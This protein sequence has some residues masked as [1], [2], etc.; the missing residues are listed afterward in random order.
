MLEIKGKFVVCKGSLAPGRLPMLTAAALA[1]VVL[2][3][4]TGRQ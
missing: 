1:A 3:I 4:I 2:V